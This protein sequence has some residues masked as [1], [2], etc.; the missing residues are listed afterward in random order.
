MFAKNP[1]TSVIILLLSLASLSLLHAGP[2]DD[3]AKIDALITEV[4]TLK[5]AMFIR[6]VKEYDSHDAAKFLRAKW[7]AKRDKIRTPAEFIDKVATRSSTTGKPYLIRLK[8]GTV[9]PCATYLKA[10]LKN[11][12]T[13]T[14]RQG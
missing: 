5:T 2:A 13:G 7:N 1:L 8:D 3:H 6:N 14:S 12:T 9:T 10:R 4:Q 11:P